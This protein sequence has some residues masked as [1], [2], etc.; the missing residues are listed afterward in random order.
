MDKKIAAVLSAAICV[1]QRDQSF[2]LRTAKA[3]PAASIIIASAAL[4]PSTPVGGASV[5]GAV[6]VD[7]TVVSLVVVVVSEDSVVVSV[8]VSM[9][10]VVVVVVSVSVVV[11][12]TSA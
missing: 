11:V 10:T 6:V 12:V 3:V 7:V 8:A 9:S 5:E 2:F 1:I 4:T